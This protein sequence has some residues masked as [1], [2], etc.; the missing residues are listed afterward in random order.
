MLG[1]LA[2]IPDPW[3][4]SMIQCNVDII[5]NKCRKV[6]LEVLQKGYITDSKKFSEDFNIL[7][8]ILSAEGHD[9]N[10]FSETVV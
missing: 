3:I 1:Q 9:E 10:F 5:P 8:N 2:V 6:F 4:M 7:L